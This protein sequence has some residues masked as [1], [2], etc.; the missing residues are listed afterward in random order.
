MC[1]EEDHTRYAPTFEFGDAWI[2]CVG[3]CLF[4]GEPHRRGAVAEGRVGARKYL[5]GLRVVAS[6][7]DPASRGCGATGEGDAV[8]PDDDGDDLRGTWEDDTVVALAVP[9]RPDAGKCV[10]ESVMAGL[11]RGL[12]AVAQCFVFGSEVGAGRRARTEWTLS[13]LSAVRTPERDRCSKF[14]RI[15]NRGKHNGLLRRNVRTALT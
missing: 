2:C 14:Q 6:N 5:G 11:E 15:R 4:I 12:E 3:K 10:E 1:R 8:H 7:V 9:D 13:R